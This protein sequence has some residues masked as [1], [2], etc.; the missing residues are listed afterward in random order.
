M[1]SLVANCFV[2]ESVCTE[3]G[4]TEFRTVILAMHPCHCHDSREA[5]HDSE[6]Y[7]HI[8]LKVVQVGNQLQ[9]MGNYETNSLR[10]TINDHFSH[11]D[12]YGVYEKLEQTLLLAATNNNY[13][14]ELKEVAE[15][16]KDDFNSSELE[17]QLEIFS[18]INFDSAGDSITFQD[19]CKHT[20]KVFAYILSCPNITN[21][22]STKIYTT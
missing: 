18:Q 6:Y 8:S 1:S 2:S 19:I 17:T 12:H 22:L 16:H 4:S 10:Y 14:S 15:F 9:G 11:G 3:Q 20:Y 21:S 7:L 5:H 13:S